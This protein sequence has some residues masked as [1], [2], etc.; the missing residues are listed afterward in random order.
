[1]DINEVS[2]AS[3]VAASAIRFYEEKGLI[4]SI[5]RKGLRR[6]FPAS[7]LQRLA[8]ISLARNAGFSLN[9]I[10]LMVTPHGTR[11]DRALLKTKADEL[12]KKIRIMTSMR[13][14][15]LHAAACPTPN[16]FECPKFLRLLRISGKKPPKARLG[17]AHR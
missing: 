6:L 16:H 15:L 2:K 14:G 1:M 8:V 17:A 7:I 11:I 12:N 5:G 10:K 9:E 4:Q 13:D 3:G